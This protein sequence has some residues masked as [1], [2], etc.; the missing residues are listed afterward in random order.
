MNR[1]EIYI[2]PENRKLLEEIQKQ[3]KA[4]SLSETIKNLINKYNGGK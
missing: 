3:M 1:L 2:R 4:K